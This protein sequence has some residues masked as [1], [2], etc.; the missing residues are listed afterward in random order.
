MYSKSFRVRLLVIISAIAVIPVI[1]LS[2]LFFVSINSVFAERMD[3]ISSGIMSQLIANIEGK[4]LDL[5]EFCSFLIDDIGVQ[6]LLE[7]PEES[8]NI[9]DVSLFSVLSDIENQFSYRS[10]TENILSLFIIG[11]NGLFIGRAAE[12]GLIPEEEIRLIDRNLITDRLWSGLIRNPS[13]ITADDEIVAFRRAII[14]D[15]GQAIGSILIFLSECFFSDEYDLLLGDEDFSISIT[16]EDGLLLSSKG[17]MDGRTD[18]VDSVSDS[19][20]HYYL[21]YRSGIMEAEKMAILEIAGITVFLVV[22]V[23]VLFSSF[24]SVHLSEP[25][26][27]MMRNL[28]RIGEG[29]FDNLSEISNKTE[30]GALNRNIIG[31]S[32]RLQL[33]IA[34]RVEKEKEN[35]LLEFRMLQSQI[36]PHFIYNTLN[37][38]SALARMQGRNNIAMMIEALGNLLRTSFKAKTITIPLGEELAIADSY[39]LICRMRTNNMIGFTKYCDASLDNQVP[40]FLLQPLL[41]NS[42]S[43]GFASGNPRGSIVLSVSETDTSLLVEVSDDGEGISG[44]RLVEIQELL[45]KASDEG[46]IEGKN[47]GL[48]NIQRR[49]TLLYGKG[50]GVSI[51]SIKGKGTTTSVCLPRRPL[52]EDSSC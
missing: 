21:G 51:S 34:E 41:E 9:F 33:L 22:I 49:I 3:E 38:I 26:H 45:K 44:D 10:V 37:S 13:P 42:L 17:Y 39:M 8:A 2:S 50:Y 28:K 16:T 11:E 46:P 43:H 1:L 24:L 6:E 52:N 40:R 31:M 20:W 18:K 19:G 15:S 30:L 48:L 25:I 47:V 27:V 29:R 4:A 14:N 5:S 12:A 36:N 35:S 32:K 7:R 23:L